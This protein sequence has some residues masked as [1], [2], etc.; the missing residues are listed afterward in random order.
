MEKVG[1]KRSS[2]DEV[3]FF[4]GETYCV[5]T[6]WQLDKGC[7]NDSYSGLITETQKLNFKAY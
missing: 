4:Q 2:T 6:P 1:Y 5:K 7:N 3:V